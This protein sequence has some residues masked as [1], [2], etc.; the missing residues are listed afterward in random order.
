MP[1]D[2]VKVFAYYTVGC[3]AH[4]VEIH[5]ERAQLD[6]DDMKDYRRNT[7]DLKPTDNFNG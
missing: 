7:Q 4:D 2:G 1:R 3:S 5:P 6:R